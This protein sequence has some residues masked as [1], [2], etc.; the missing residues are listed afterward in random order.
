MFFKTHKI[1]Q[2]PHKGV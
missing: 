1:M 2:K